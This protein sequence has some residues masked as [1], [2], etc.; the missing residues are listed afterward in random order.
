MQFELQQNAPFPYAGYLD[1]AGPLGREFN[2]ITFP[3]NLQVSYQELY[4][5]MVSRT[6]NHTWSKS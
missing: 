2:R 5:V 4:S 6:S 1:R 3:F